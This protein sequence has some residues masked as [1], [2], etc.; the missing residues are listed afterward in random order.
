MNIYPLRRRAALSRLA[1]AALLL[2]GVAGS[3][4]AADQISLAAGGRFDQLERELEARAAQGP[5]DTRDRHALCYAYSKTKR[6]T[7][8]MDCLD[9]LAL[10]L[11]KGDLRTRLFALDDA[12]PALG[13]MRAEAWLELG[14]YALAKDEA[15]HTLDWLKQDSN[16]DRDMMFQTLALLSLA[17]AL[18]GERQQGQAFAQQLAATSAGF[19]GPYASAKAMAMARV[20]MALDDYGGVITELNG[21]ISFTYNVLLDRLLSGGYFTGVNNWVWVELPR[22][23]MMSKA[24][25]ESGRLVEAKAGLER[26]LQITQVKENREIYWLLLSDRGRIAALEHEHAPALTFFRQ[27]LDIVEARDISVNTEA[28]KIGFVGDKQAL[29]VRAIDSALAL[30]QADLASDLLERAKSRALADE[31]AQK[32]AF[33]PALASTQESR[34]ALEHYIKAADAAGAQLPIDMGGGSHADPAAQ[35]ENKRTYSPH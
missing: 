11:K 13:L 31:L 3:G 25:M 12:T 27:A 32:N 33:V 30:H 4:S 1:L 8:L 16:D 22:A 14:Q 23:Y 5:L 10:N 20:R 35:S 26:L 2:C 24:L 29:Y 34:I 6:Y 17:H 7:R 18:A 21:D 28:G 19:R 15:Q 9:Q